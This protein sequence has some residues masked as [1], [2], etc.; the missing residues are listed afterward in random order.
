MLL[1]GLTVE[2]YKAV[3]TFNFAAPFVVY[4]R[5]FCAFHVW[6]GFSL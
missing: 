5:R 6:W 3:L 2:Y 1:F 4:D